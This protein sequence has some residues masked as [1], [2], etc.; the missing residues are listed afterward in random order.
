MIKSVNVRTEVLEE[1]IAGEKIGSKY[2]MDKWSLL[3]AFGE[4]VPIDTVHYG[5]MIIDEIRRAEG[6]NDL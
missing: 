4:G 1:E 2:S 3:H 5:L 6:S